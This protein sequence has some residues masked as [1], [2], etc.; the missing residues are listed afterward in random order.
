ML[1]IK[2]PSQILVLRRLLFF[3]SNNYKVLQIKW[4]LQAQ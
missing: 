3:V 1:K 4:N 2:K